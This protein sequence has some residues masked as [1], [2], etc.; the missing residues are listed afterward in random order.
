LPKALANSFLARTWLLAALWGLVFLHVNISQ[1][2]RCFCWVSRKEFLV[3]DVSKI[4][5]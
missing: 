2:D 5:W 4:S 1:S 3:Q